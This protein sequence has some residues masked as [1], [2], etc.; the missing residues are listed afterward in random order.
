MRDHT[1]SRVWAP[2][3]A[4][5]SSPRCIASKLL[6]PNNGTKD[7]FSRWPDAKGTTL[8]LKRHT[9]RSSK[10]IV[11]LDLYVMWKEHLEDWELTDDSAKLLYV[12]YPD[13][14]WGSSNS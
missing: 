10:R 4:S 11:L 8:V 7:G 1:R 9:V 2:A 5:S 13:E 14:N 3:L 6:C 12:A